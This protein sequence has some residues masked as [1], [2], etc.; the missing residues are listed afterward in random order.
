MIF[1]VLESSVQ[2][3]KHIALSGIGKLK[4][5]CAHFEMCNFQSKLI[6]LD[7]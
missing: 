3:L 4:V 5:G 2:E 1:Y 6:D 7:P